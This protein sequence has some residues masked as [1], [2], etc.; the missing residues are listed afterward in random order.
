MI[1]GLVNAALEAT[2]PLLLQG[3]SGQSQLVDAVIDTGFTGFLTLPKVLVNT[4]Q[5]PWIRRTV[6]VL[7]DGSQRVFDVYEVIVT[8]DGKTRTVR[9]EEA[10]AIPLIGMSFLLGT[11][12]RISVVQGGLRNSLVRAYAARFRAA[13]SDSTRINCR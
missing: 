4:L 13:A 6:G 11:D 12:L 2:I 9:V 3:S 7:A 1:T 10:D 5:L 8:W